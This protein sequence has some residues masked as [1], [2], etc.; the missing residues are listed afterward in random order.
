METCGYIQQDVVA[1][2]TLAVSSINIS[3]DIS[4]SANDLPLLAI[5]AHYITCGGVLKH[6]LIGLK[7]VT[8]KHDG[9]KIASHVSEVI[10]ELGIGNKLGF[11]MLDNAT[12]NDTA[13]RALAIEYSFSAQ[14]RRLRC[15]G[16]SST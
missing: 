5:V 4:T 1:E 8:G 2:L 6:L 9:E 14:Q 12:N 13:I 16:P 7:H 11:F 3:F 10:K 15:A